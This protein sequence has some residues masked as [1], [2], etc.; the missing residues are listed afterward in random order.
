MN[1]QPA[2]IVNLAVTKL[3]LNAAACLIPLVVDF[4]PNQM[5]TTNYVKHTTDFWESF[6]S[7]AENKLHD[8]MTLLWSD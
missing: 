5:L 4:Q 2:N 3:E 7:S 6:H 1:V 8:R